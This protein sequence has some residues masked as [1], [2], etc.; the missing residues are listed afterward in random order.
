MTKQRCLPTLVSSWT[1][2]NKGCGASASRAAVDSG[3]T[4]VNYPGLDDAGFTFPA[5]R[6]SSMGIQEFLNGPFL[7][8][9]CPA[10][11]PGRAVNQT[12]PSD[13]SASSY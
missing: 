6:T 10:L 2:V 13:T 4:F 5:I 7:A 8:F 1:L 9:R 12:F 3:M 11:H